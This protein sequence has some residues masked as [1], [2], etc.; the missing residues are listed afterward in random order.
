[1]EIFSTPADLFILEV[2]AV[3]T[4][5]TLAFFQFFRNKKNIGFIVEIEQ[6]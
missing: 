1:M 4:G 3:P 6:T 5:F 2:E